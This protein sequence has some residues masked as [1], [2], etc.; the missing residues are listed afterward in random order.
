MSPPVETL[1]HSDGGDKGAKYQSGFREIKVLFAEICVPTVAVTMPRGP[2][3]RRRGRMGKPGIAGRARP[4]G[5]GLASRDCREAWIPGR[6]A[7]WLMHPKFLKR[8]IH[9]KRE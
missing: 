9:L 2:I 7:P 3:R 6:I 8:M 1:T 5:Q 4:H